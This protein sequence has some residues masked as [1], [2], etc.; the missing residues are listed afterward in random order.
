MNRSRHYAIVGSLI[1]AGG[2]AAA[3]ASR[4]NTNK[5][6]ADAP[7]PSPEAPVCRLSVGDRAAFRLSSEVAVGD[8]TDHFEGTMSWQV[9]EATDGAAK[10]RA[11]FS[12]VR[13]SQDLTLPDERS[14]SP[15]GVAFY[16]EVGDD[17]AIR[18]TAFAPSW[19]V[20]TRLLVRT[21]LDNHAFTLPAAGATQWQA[22]AAD[23]LGQHRA[24]FVL[25][26]TSPWTI[27]RTKTAHRP[28]G[29]SA[30]LGIDLSL[31]RAEATA[32]F[33]ID[34]PQWWQS[35][36]GEEQVTIT[37]AG[38]APVTMTQRFSLQ[39]DDA[40][41][42]TVPAL[43]DA[44]ADGRDPRHMPLTA[45]TETTAHTSYAD[46]LS[47]FEAAV[48]DRDDHQAAHV[49]AAWLR[50]HPEDV[51]RLVA[52]LRGDLDDELRPAVFLAMELS[53]TDA[54]RDALGDLIDDD[55][56][57]AL[58]QAR[59]ASALSDIGQPTSAVAEQ[60]LARAE[61][62]DMAGRVSLLGLGS[63]AGRADEKLRDELVGALHDRHQAAE[64]DGGL[65][66]VID[67]MGNSGEASFAEALGGELASESAATRRHA[68]DALAKL[69]AEDAV[70]RLVDQLRA[71]ED[72]HVG[73]SL[74]RAV[75]ATKDR[76]PET[77]S[78]MQSRLD[79][80]SLEERAAI[81]KWLGGHGSPEAQRM[82]VAQF[83]R[84]DNARLKQ[85]IGRYVS[86]E[87]LQ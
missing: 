31:G 65:H 8:Q 25:E 15:E 12:D 70:P 20:R 43:D 32:T 83:H 80:A 72:P 22:P 56:L 1:V 44:L 55:A 27:H 4:T 53:G 73:V 41:F 49:L 75:A 61:T 24:S 21:Q 9:V 71:E 76:S 5:H 87:A 48:Q 3:V 57:S 11:A 63:M 10:V 54:S 35:T 18:E 78:V 28:H 52:E 68:A 2:I 47:A 17:C 40:R 51:N 62:D 82:L 37:A 33:D 46:A 29:D 26:G 45:Q 79:G 58:D 14:A 38:R 66:L 6:G 19:D 23:G 81:I 86:A 67:A 69:P 16:L 77:L 13:L 34:A 30:A 7:S 42:A 74:V 85:S 36:Q 64:T 60:L 50:A 39:R 84:E 59:A